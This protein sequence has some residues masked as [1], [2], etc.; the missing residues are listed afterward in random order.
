MK[1]EKEEKYLDFLLLIQFAIENIYQIKNVNEITSNFHTAIE[2]ITKE[3]HKQ[4]EQISGT[5][6]PHQFIGQENYTFQFQEDE[7]SSGEF[8]LDFLPTD[9]NEYMKTQFQAMAEKK[10]ILLENNKRLANFR[11]QLFIDGLFS[12]LKLKKK[13]KVV[14]NYIVKQHGLEN[15]TQQA[16]DCAQLSRQKTGIPIDCWYFEKNGTSYVITLCFFGGKSGVKSY[17]S[18][19]VSEVFESATV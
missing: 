16:K 9:A 1:N 14:Y 11:I 4:F 17:L 18:F 19:S 15:L 2:N 8:S 7:K 12:R 6:L 3:R 10:E 13:Y 5:I